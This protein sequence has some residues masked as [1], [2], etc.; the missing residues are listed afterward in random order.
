MT[1]H[2][3]RSS[4]GPDAEEITIVIDRLD[5]SAG[6]LNVVVSFGCR[7]SDGVIDERAFVE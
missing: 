6:D 7:R 5:A 3:E 4:E 1:G 2:Q